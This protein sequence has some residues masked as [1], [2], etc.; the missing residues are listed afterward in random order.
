M[1]NSLWLDGLQHARLLCPPVSPGVCSN[2]YLLSWWCCLTISSST[3]PLSFCLQSF[4]AWGS[5]PMSRLFTAG[6]W[7]TAASASCIKDWLLLGLTGWFD[8]SAVKG[9]LQ[10]L[11]QHQR[12][13]LQAH[14]L[15]S[16]R[17]AVTSLIFP[18]CKSGAHFGSTR[19]KS[20]H[21]LLSKTFQQFHKLLSF[22]S[23]YGM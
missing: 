23:S 1:L 22:I 3:A 19:Y 13:I 8:L 16:T 17:T 12:D 15:V 2:P 6:G 5:L 4:P 9:I 14:L 21:S 18:K 7:S 10:S 20:V 11:L